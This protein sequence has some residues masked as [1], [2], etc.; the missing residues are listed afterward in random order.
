[1]YFRFQDKLMSVTEFI[2]SM[3][4]KTR[5]NSLP[6]A[7]PQSN[8]STKNDTRS[9]SE[10]QFINI[11]FFTEEKLVTTVKRRYETQVPIFLFLFISNEF[12]YYFHLNRFQILFQK[13]YKNYHQKY[14]LKY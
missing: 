14:A 10:N 7:M 12:I 8:N 4:R 9:T 5:Q 1:M 6:S 2:E 3:Q 11:V 13:H